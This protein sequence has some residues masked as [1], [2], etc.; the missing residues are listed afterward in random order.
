MPQTQQDVVD[1]AVLRI[2]HPAPDDDGH[3]RRRR[4]GHEDRELR[5]RTKPQ[6]FQHRR[7]QQQRHAEPDQHAQNDRQRGEPDHRVEQQVPEVRA[8]QE[9][10]VIVESDPI[11]ALPQTQ[12]REVGEALR[13]I[14]E[15][16]IRIEQREDDERRREHQR[17]EEPFTAHVESSR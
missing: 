9:L 3:D 13:Q 1:D 14:L 10:A 16:R 15:R 2:E 11:A 5:S 12:E 17:N 6:P 7:V 8:R 4:P